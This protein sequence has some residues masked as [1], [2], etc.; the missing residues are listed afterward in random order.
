MWYDDPASS[1]IETGVVHLSAYIEMPNESH[2][3]QMYLPSAF[4][5][6]EEKQIKE[7]HN[8]ILHDFI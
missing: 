4:S 1:Y 2:P 5:M 6:C 3:E 7:D 8:N